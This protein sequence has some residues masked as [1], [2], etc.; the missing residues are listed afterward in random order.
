MGTGSMTMADDLASRR[1]SAHDR[2]GGTGRRAG[3]LAGMMAGMVSPPLPGILPS[4]AI[5]VMTIFLVL[6]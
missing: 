5:V 6:W 1:P 3:Q 2:G 4:P